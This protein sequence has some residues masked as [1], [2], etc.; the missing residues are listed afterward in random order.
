MQISGS[1]LCLLKV[2]FAECLKTGKLQVNDVLTYI[3][4]V[5]K[6]TVVT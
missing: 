4:R 3:P 5:I 6:I 2:F 1:V